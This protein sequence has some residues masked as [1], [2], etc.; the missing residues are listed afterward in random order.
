MKLPHHG[1][2]ANLTDELAQEAWKLVGELEAAGG[3]AEALASGDV[4]A[5]I[6]AT[7]QARTASPRP[8]GTCSRR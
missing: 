8:S 3:M 4:A 5:R 7:R 1:S 6:D 2:G